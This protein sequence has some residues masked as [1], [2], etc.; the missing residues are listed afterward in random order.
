MQQSP[1]F[2]VIVATILKVI[3]AIILIAFVLVIGA[4]VIDQFVWSFTG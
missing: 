2:W 4:L 3:L 1:S